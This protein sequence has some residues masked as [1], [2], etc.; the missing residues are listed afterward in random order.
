[1]RVALRVPIVAGALILASNGLFLAVASASSWHVDAS[2][3]ATGNYA[4]AETNA[5]ATKPSKAEIKVTGPAA[6]SGLVQ[7]SIE[8]N[9][10]SG[11]AGT[12]KTGKV[13]LKFPGTE[14]LKVPAKSSL[15]EIAANVQIQGSGKVA[16]SIESK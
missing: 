7:W 4:V 16:I 5:E 6:L 8:C 3:H 15:C 12:T 14:L 1:M 11:A 13:T 9:T 2:A 10:N